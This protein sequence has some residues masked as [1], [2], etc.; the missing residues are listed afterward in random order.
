MIQGLDKATY[1]LWSQVA[2]GGAIK[3]G[4]KNEYFIPSYAK[5]VTEVK[6]GDKVTTPAQPAGILFS[7]G[8]SK[9]NPE[10]IVYSTLIIKAKD[11]FGHEAVIKIS[12][13]EVKKRQY[14]VSLIFDY[15]KDY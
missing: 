2:K 15:Y 9:Q 4:S 6:D 5:E 12:D 13:L 3:E 11:Y 14:L 10:A 1:E 8:S 7:K